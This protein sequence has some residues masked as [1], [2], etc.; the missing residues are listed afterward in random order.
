[1]ASIPKKELPAYVRKC[2][3]DWQKANKTNREAEIERLRFYVGGDLQW[4]DEELRK[5][6]QTQRPHITINK[7]KPAVDQI[8]GDIRLNPPGPQC[9]PVGNGADKDTAD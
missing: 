4:R 3:E 9:H 2:W 5:R 6:K 8:E 7:C 1:M